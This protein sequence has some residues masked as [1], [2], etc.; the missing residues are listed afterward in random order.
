MLLN[1]NKSKLLGTNI[2][3]LSD[4]RKECQ[5]RTWYDVC[6]WFGTRN[7]DDEWMDEFII[8]MLNVN[9]KNKKPQPKFSM[10]F[11][12]ELISFRLTFF[13]NKL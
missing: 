12:N 1:T 13:Q 9:H 11:S 7:G 4:I 6:W 5:G 3:H 8:S 2:F 10:S